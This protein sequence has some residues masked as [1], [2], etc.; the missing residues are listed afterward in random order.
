MEETNAIKERTLK[1]NP[2]RKEHKSKQGTVPT[3]VPLLH[4]STYQSDANA[5]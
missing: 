1:K 5:T 4:P 3:T 2:H